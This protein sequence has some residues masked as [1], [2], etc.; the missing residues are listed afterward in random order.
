MHLQGTGVVG[1]HLQGTGVVGM[2]LHG[3]G[4]V[5]LAKSMP[6]TTEDSSK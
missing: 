6:G 4:V 5:V 1:M 3:T 2:H